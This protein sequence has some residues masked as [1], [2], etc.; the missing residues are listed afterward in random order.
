[1]AKKA[2]TILIM[3]GSESTRWKGKLPKELALIEGKYLLRRTVDQVKQWGDPWI[4]THKPEILELFDRTLV[5]QKHRW[6]PETLLS[7]RASWQGKVIV[8]NGDVVFS[9]NA[10]K[11]IFSGALRVY[12]QRTPSW[13]AFALSFRPQDYER[14][15]LAA[16]KAVK[17]G[18][19]GQRSCIWEVYR[20]L[21]GFDL[22]SQYQFDNV[23]WCEINDFTTDFDIVKRYKSFL[24]SHPWAR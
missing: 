16:K 10:L 11:T 3:A 23:I 19:K 17:H 2:L 4:V 7:T 18:E 22:A 24:R 5:P 15:M 8:L 12:G 20:A 9:M 6:W 1:M 21:C 13:E 14:V